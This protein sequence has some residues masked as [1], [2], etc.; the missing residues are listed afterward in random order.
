MELF[1]TMDL[2][3]VPSAAVLGLHRLARA[4]I[5]GCEVHAVAVPRSNS[6]VI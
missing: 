3:L 2:E 1:H 4:V 6:T 5:A